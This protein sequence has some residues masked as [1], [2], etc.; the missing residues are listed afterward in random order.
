MSSEPCQN[1]HN[2]H[3]EQL[4][5]KSGF[6]S[7]NGDLITFYVETRDQGKVYMSARCT[8]YN[9]EQKSVVFVDSQK[10]LNLWKNDPRKHEAKL[11][12]GNKEIW[13][14]D[15]K[16][17]AAEKGFSYGILNPVPLAY[18]TCQICNKNGVYAAFTNGITRTIWLLAHG[19]SSFP[20]EVDNEEADLL[21]KHA[22][23]GQE[24]MPAYKHKHFTSM[25][26]LK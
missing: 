19:A 7:Y 14:S 17:A 3:S 13:K 21:N 8:E 23:T 26:R 6:Q 25:P 2:Q 15:Y 9:N 22:G 1:F 24:P 10:F 12:N 4:K 18:P 11:A 20:V 16:Y 5:M